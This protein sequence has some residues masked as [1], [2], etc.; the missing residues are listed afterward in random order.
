MRDSGNG[1][2]AMDGT[3]M[4]APHVTGAIALLVAV[5]MPLLLSSATQERSS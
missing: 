4:A 3:S 2:Y 1:V 5:A